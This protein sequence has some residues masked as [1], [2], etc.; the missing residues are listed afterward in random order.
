V[1]SGPMSTSHAPR[2]YLQLRKTVRSLSRSTELQSSAKWCSRWLPHDPP[3]LAMLLFRCL[4]SCSAFRLSRCLLPA[5][6]P[7]LQLRSQKA[8]NRSCSCRASRASN[9]SCSCRASLDTQPVGLMKAQQRCLSAERRKL[10]N[11]A[12]PKTVADTLEP[13]E[14]F[15]QTY[16]TQSGSAAGAKSLQSAAVRQLPAAHACPQPC[17]PQPHAVCRMFF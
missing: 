2:I 3:N 15:T 9:R 12:Q 10:S 1:L 8:S 6:L 16:N 4:V 11:P 14:T 17:L 13:R 5:A 7:W